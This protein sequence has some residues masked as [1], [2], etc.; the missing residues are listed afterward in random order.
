[1]SRDE[2]G[3]GVCH[4]WSS[5]P[6]MVVWIL[7]AILVSVSVTSYFVSVND[8]WRD[9]APNG[10]YHQRSY[11]TVSSNYTD[12]NGNPISDLSQNATMIYFPV[13]DHAYLGPLHGNFK[14]TCQLTENGRY[15]FHIVN[16]VIVEAKL[17]GAE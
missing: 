7:I 16:N 14:I 2:A 9:G 6:F 5:W 13:C 10:W 12:Y 8:Y 3:G 1:M 4:W 15:D 11:V 17:Y